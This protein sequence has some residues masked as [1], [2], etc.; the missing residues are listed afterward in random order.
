MEWI[1][2]IRDG[3]LALLSRGAMYGYQLRTEFEASTGSTWPLNI[4]QVYSTLQRLERDGLVAPVEDGTPPGGDRRRYEL[5]EAGRAELDRWFARPVPR[6]I[7]D[8]DEVAIKLVMAVT[9][10]GVDVRAMIQTQRA[11][12]MAALQAVTRAKA[13]AAGDLRAS[14]VADSVIFSAEAEIRWL[15][16]CESRLLAVSAGGTGT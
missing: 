9:V 12:T 8:R 10:P 2:V 15:D 1:L 5:T 16:H 13:G 3:L 14:L 7:P 6:E 11:A 4:G